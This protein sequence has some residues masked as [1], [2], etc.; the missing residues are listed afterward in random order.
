MSPAPPI[1]SIS[2]ILAAIALTAIPQALAQ[3]SQPT[4][5][6]A[7]LEKWLLGAPA[8]EQFIAAVLAPLRRYDTDQ[9]G[10]DAQ[11]IE[12]VEDANEARLRA[13]RV[14]RIL[15]NDIDGDGRVTRE[16][17]ATSAERQLKP[18]RGA[19]P[20]PESDK[21]LEQMVATVMQADTDG[22]GVITFDEMRAPPKGQRSRQGHT[23]AG[24]AKS[25]LTLDPNKDGRLTAEELTKLASDTFQRF[26]KDGSGLL[27]ADELEP[28]VVK[29]RSSMNQ[30]QQSC[31]L[32]KPAGDEQVVVFGTYE[33]Q[34]TSTVSVVGMDRE[35]STGKITIE[36]GDKPLYMV[37][38]SYDAMIWQFAGETKRVSRAVVIPRRH[39]EGPGAGVTGLRSDQVSFLEPGSCFGH[40]RD[41]KSGKALQARAVVEREL[42]RPV[43]VLSGVY[44]LGSIRLPSGQPQQSPR[45][46]QP[47]PPGVDERVW[48]DFIRFN[49]D[50]VSEID[51]AGVVAPEPAQRYDVLPQEAGIVQLVQDG[52]LKLLSDG[53]FHIVKPIARFPA[54]LNGAHSVTFLLGKGIAMPAGAP[55]HSC[56]ISE[57]TGEQLRRS[58]ICRSR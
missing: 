30:P 41:D 27:S 25:L 32:P 15:V 20:R 4:D 24:T 26:D 22:D 7:V 29:L 50:G 38:S 11:D 42:G 45:K 12:S 18:R 23:E 55:G 31:E 51:P 8:R 37:L 46:P 35:T 6:S 47:A 33:G 13:D 40:F 57:D 16:E 21:R 19:P 53:M 43:D 34:N 39:K 3:T 54:G 14:R 28:L 52:S 36:P 10:L 48:R 5:A 49:P 44:R 9:N 58:S 17:V 56:V 2:A 1:R